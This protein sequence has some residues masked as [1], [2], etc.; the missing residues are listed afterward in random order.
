MPFNPKISILTSLYHS[1]RYLSEFLKQVEAQSVFADSELIVVLNEGTKKEQ[2]SI[3]DFAAL[4]P[5]KLILLSV[6]NVEALG[7][8]WNRAWQAARAPYLAIWNVDDR[9]V[10]DSLERQMKALDS[11]QDWMICYGDYERVGEYG[12]EK[13]ARRKTPSYSKGVF[14][15]SFPQGG[16][17]WLLR[18]ELAELVGQFDEQF[19]VAPDLDLSVRIAVKGLEMGRV[20][21]LLGYFTDEGVGLSTR[22]E[23]KLSEIE[24]TAI[25]L[26]HGVYDK[27][28]EELRG[29]AA[30]YDIDH[31][32]IKGKW[33][34]LLR[35][36]P[37]LDEYRRRRKMLWSLGT[38]RNLL[39][40]LLQ[41]TG[42]LQLVYA[43]QKRLIKREI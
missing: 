27:V 42:L 20:E 41:K 14:R 32:R 8:S 43:I 15:R 29:Q 34:P 21:G 28:R 24:R 17:F 22:D 25:Q 9:R 37:E 16:A 18:R 39:R 5:E 6:E 3:Q 30:N 1:E 7:A 11:Y 23:S 36:L 10:P 19:T 13:G 35:Y 31:I 38:L 4:Y 33:Q 12:L 26:R 2:E 40:S